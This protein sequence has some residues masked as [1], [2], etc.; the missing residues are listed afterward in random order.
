[1]SSPPDKM[2]HGTATPFD[3]FRHPQGGGTDAG[4]LGEGVYLTKDPEIA[5]S[6]ATMASG[7]QPRVITAEHGVRSPLVLRSKD[8]PVVEAAAKMLGVTESPVWDGNKQTSRAWSQ[9]FK[10]RALAAGYDGVYAADAGEMVA[11]DPDFVKITKSVPVGGQGHG[12]RVMAQDPTIKALEEDLLRLEKPLRPGQRMSDAAFERWK[13]DKQNVKDDIARRRREIESMMSSERMPGTPAGKSEARRQA[14]KAAQQRAA[15]ELESKIKK[16][17]GSGRKA[18]LNELETD[19]S[20]YG[21]L[22]PKK[23]KQL[24]KLRA[25]RQKAI[26]KFAPKALATGVAAKLMLGGA[27]K[28]AGLPG[29]GE[30]I[31][32]AGREDPSLQQFFREIEEGITG[33]LDLPQRSQ[34]PVFSM[35]PARENVARIMLRTGRENLRTGFDQPAITKQELEYVKKKAAPRPK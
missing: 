8:R 22:S 1:M 28:A 26:A 20:Y 15:E 12:R 16:E 18:L 9:E 31:E 5:R 13:R 4:V 30:V 19:L 27:A 32:V 24:T 11:F 29:V 6:Y 17:M 23:Q 14:A 35:D 7:S 25:A 21:E 2:F 3:W 34:M 33:A 10:E